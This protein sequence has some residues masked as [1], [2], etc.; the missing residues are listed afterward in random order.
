MIFYGY[1]INVTIT[2]NTSN[3][4]R[5]FILGLLL[6]KNHV[7]YI[8]GC[9]LPYSMLVESHGIISGIKKILTNGEVTIC[10][11]KSKLFIL[12]D[13]RVHSGKKVRLD[14]GRQR[15]Y[16]SQKI[17]SPRVQNSTMWN[18]NSWNTFFASIF[19]MKFFSY[20]LKAHLFSNLFS[21]KLELHFFTRFSSFSFETKNKK[22]CALSLEQKH[23]FR[24]QI[25][26]F[27]DNRRG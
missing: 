3:S 9:I 1:K 18:S 15:W 5:I 27:F 13:N 7:S 20:K 12:G 22:M 2:I 26:A 6:Y 25:T 8:Y 4:L 16:L 19:C 10:D 14:F 11:T 24:K 23:L 17:V 21:F